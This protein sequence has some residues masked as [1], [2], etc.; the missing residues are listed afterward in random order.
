MKKNNGCNIFGEK[1]K[2]Q[3][4]IQEVENKQIMSVKTD[5]SFKVISHM[6]GV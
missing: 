3:N 4:Y 1:V 6:E 2:N 5:L